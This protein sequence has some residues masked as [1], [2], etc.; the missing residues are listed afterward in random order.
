MP[1]VNLRVW[2]KALFCDTSESS[3]FA[4]L[5]AICSRFLPAS[6][7][8]AGCYISILHDNA[9]YLPLGPRDDCRKAFSTAPGKYRTLE[10]MQLMV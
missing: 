9:S 10:G 5:L 2:A 3:L 7:L 6:L 4:K 1:Y 8:G